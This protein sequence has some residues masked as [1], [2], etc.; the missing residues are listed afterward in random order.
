MR[1]FDDE[2]YLPSFSR[3]GGRISALGADSRL[4]I[5]DL[6]LP[7]NEPLIIDL[8]ASGLK[9]P[10]ESPALIRDARWTIEGDRLTIVRF[11]VLHPSLPGELASF[12]LRTG[13]ELARIAVPNEPH[14]S[15]LSPDGRYFVVTNW[16]GTGQIDFYS[17]HHANAVLHSPK[18]DDLDPS[19][20]APRFST[21]GRHLVLET[22]TMPGSGKRVSLHFRF[23]YEKLRESLDAA[24]AV[25]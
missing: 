11:D 6:S 1:V 18:S 25:P 8:G 21:D 12:D 15:A 3:D 9:F 13:Q 2:V 16:K 7:G 10:S 24:I 19:L 4:R 23:D 20:V 5:W 14:H 22:P 17:T